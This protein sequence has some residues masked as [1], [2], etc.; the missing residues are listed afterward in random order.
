MGQAFFCTFS[1]KGANYSLFRAVGGVLLFPDGRSIRGLVFHWSLPIAAIGAACLSSSPHRQYDRFIAS[2][3]RV[4]PLRNRLEPLAEE[5]REP[6]I[7]FE[8]PRCQ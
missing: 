1:A 5:E 8:S 7:Q 3:F 6:G 2:P 4:M